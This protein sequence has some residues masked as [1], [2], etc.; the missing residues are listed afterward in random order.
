MK[1]HL[2]RHH[3]NKLNAMGGDIFEMLEKTRVN[4]E[5]NT[6]INNDSIDSND[7]KS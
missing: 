7:S 2:Q 1:R 6:D 4:D 5:E 3:S